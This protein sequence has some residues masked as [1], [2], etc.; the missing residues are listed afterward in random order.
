MAI[1]G[2]VYERSD[3]T[4]SLAALSA[5]ASGVGGAA[6][7]AIMQMQNLMSTMLLQKTLSSLSLSI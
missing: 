6:A 4:G 7:A 2:V 1:F 3:V 5:D